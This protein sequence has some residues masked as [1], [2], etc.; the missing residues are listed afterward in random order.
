MGVDLIWRPPRFYAVGAVSVDQGSGAW[1]SPGML[2]G[3][4][5]GV[6]RLTSLN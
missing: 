6:T 3:T 1:D 2:R 5:S 4:W